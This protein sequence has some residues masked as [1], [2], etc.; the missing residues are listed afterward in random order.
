[1]KVTKIF[2]IQEYHMDC[3]RDIYCN[4]MQVFILEIKVKYGITHQFT[5]VHAIV[6]NIQKP[7]IF[8][9]TTKIIS[10][11][12]F[13]TLVHNISAPVTHNAT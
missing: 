7:H 9:N 5:E 11:Y 2:S 1:M 4:N 13:E 8:L 3:I 10:S 12:P 6:I